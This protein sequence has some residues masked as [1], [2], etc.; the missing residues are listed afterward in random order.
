MTRELVFP[1]PQKE[2]RNYCSASPHT[3]EHLS[4]SEFSSGFCWKNG[5][6]TFANLTV[7]C[8]NTL[9]SWTSALDP[10]LHYPR[11]SQ[12]KE[13]SSVPFSYCNYLQV[14]SWDQMDGDFTKTSL[15][16]VFL[17]KSLNSWSSFNQQTL[18]WMLRHLRS[19][20]ICWGRL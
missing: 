7:F 3:C 11:N 16:I 17:S 1:A 9:I 15:S 6:L 20:K 14:N 19:S 18:S 13:D 8:E 5:W 12:E 10:H 4:V 2:Q